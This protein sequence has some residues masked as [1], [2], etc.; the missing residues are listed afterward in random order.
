MAEIKIAEAVEIPSPDPARLGKKD[1]WVTY[2]VDGTR[3]YSIIIPAE[4][5]TEA[6]IEAAIRKAETERQKL[7]GKTFEV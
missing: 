2:T 3:T 5:A 1:T 7:I 4:L 6:E